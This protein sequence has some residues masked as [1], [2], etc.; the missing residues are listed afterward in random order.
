MF[1]FVLLSFRLAEL[2]AAM[3]KHAW[4]L[5]AE[6]EG[7]KPGPPNEELAKLKHKLLNFLVGEKMYVSGFLGGVERK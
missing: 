6:R 7:R 1:A 2:L 5:V 4:E 3:E